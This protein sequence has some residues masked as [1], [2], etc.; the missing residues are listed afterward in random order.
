M[1]EIHENMDY[2]VWPNRCMCVE[3]KNEFCLA[4]FGCCCCEFYAM[5]MKVL[6]GLS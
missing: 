3:V 2:G 1:N 4:C 5:K 6:N